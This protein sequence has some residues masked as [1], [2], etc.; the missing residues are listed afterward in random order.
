LAKLDEIITLHIKKVLAL[1]GGKIQGPGGAA[2]LLG[3][4]AS[5]LRHRLRKYGI[6]SGRRLP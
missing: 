6:A 3:M 2:E 1:T 5:T 4:N